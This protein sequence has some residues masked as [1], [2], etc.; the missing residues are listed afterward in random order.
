MDQ[1]GPQPFSVN[2]VLLEQSHPFMDSL[3]PLSCSN[4]WVSSFDRDCIALKGKNYYSLALWRKMPW[5]NLLWVPAMLQPSAG[6]APRLT[7]SNEAASQTV[8][9]CWWLQNLLPVTLTMH[10][11]NESTRDVRTANLE[12]TWDLLGDFAQKAQW[13][14]HWT[15]QIHSLWE[16][17]GGSWEQEAGAT[18][19]KEE[20]KTVN[21][22]SHTGSLGKERDT[23]PRVPVT[24]QA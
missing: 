14:R 12:V 9:R 18:R 8:L 22:L 1:I 23:R 16:F 4:G 15:N 10:L 24:D 6:E 7:G 11:D 2:K 19:H 13:W 21:Q 5:S 20:R 3:W 17:E